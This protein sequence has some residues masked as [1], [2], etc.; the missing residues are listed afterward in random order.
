MNNG[1]VKADIKKI[2]ESAF[3]DLEEIQSIEYSLGVWVA[4]FKRKGL[5]YVQNFEISEN[6]VTA[7]SPYCVDADVLQSAVN[8]YLTKN[9]L[10][11]GF[12]Y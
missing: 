8:R 6:G 12:I 2:I 4:I 9:N 3:T 10:W 11:R 7:N 1:L 5:D